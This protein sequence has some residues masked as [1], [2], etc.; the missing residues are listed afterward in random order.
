VLQAA[1]A[2]TALD[3][4]AQLGV[5]DDPELLGLLVGALQLVRGKDLG[6]VEEGL[7]GGSDRDVVDDGEVVEVEGARAMDGDAVVLAARAPGDGDVDGGAVRYSHVP[8][9]RSVSVAQDGTV[10]TGNDG[11]QP[12]A[13]KGRPAGSNEVDASMELREAAFRGS[14]GDPRGREAEGR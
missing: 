11:G 14:L 6:E 9:H 2:I 1:P 10:S 4:C 12:L 13:M 5:V 7:F 8:E 3:Q